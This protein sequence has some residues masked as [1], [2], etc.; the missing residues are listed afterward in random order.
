MQAN[1]DVHSAIESIIRDT[2]SRLSTPGSQFTDL[3]CDPDL[4]IVGSGLGE[5]FAGPDIACR[6]GA[7]L[8]TAGFR[9]NPG[10]IT[11][12]SHGEV[13]WAQIHGTVDLDKGT[14]LESVPY[15]TTA[16]FACVDGLWR[17]KYWGGAE[18][19]EQ[20]RV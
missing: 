5:L 3:F 4:M 13:A 19:Q 14:G 16:V 11:V 1:A 15:Y 18:P 9:W 2:Y 6:A 12:W 7:G 20:P 17:W 10:D 8:A